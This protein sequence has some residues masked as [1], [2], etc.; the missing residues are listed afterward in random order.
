MNAKVV[1]TS[2]LQGRH[3]LGV[4]RVSFQRLR[5]TVLFDELV[6]SHVT[7]ME[8]RNGS[9]EIAEHCFRGSC[10]VET[11]ETLPL[12]VFDE[13]RR[14]PLSSFNTSDF[15]LVFTSAFSE[16]LRQIQHLPTLAQSII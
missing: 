7:S 4:L 14:R 11:V 9:F 5:D 2:T 3:V 16:I 10:F 6:D 13:R 12:D 8:F 1:I 15:E